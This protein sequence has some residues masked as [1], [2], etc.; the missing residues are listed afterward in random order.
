MRPT[1]SQSYHDLN[2]LYK[3]R[4]ILFS[5]IVKT[6]ISQVWT[7][8]Q[9]SQSSLGVQWVA[10]DPKCVNAESDDPDQTGRMVNAQPE[11]SPRW[12]CMSFCSFVMLWGGPRGRVFKAS[13]L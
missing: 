12:A 13:N 2:E 5:G 8:A 6:K 9:S 3:N 4:I 1:F 7:S 10:K 11:L